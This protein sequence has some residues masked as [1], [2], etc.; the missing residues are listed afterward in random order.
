MTA[1]LQR[2]DVIHIAI[3]ANNEADG[4]K[5]FRAIAQAYA[6]EGVTI[7]TYQTNSTLAAPVV[8]AVFR[9]GAA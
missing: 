9:E 7:A 5:A 1:C 8:V 6:E 3:P 2:G 4:L